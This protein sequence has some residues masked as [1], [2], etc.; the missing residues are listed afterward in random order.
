M[1][2]MLVTIRKFCVIENSKLCR[3]VC[4]GETK[5]IVAFVQIAKF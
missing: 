5:E 1:I 4:V 3:L 2:A